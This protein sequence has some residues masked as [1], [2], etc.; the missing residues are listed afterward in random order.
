MVQ[1]I[2]VYYCAYNEEHTSNTQSYINVSRVPNKKIKTPA[3]L[4]PYEL[5]T[6]HQ[7]F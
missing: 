7:L 4:S 3:I 5:K 6:T 2:T 1:C